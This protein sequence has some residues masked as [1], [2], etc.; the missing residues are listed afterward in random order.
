MTLS[1]FSRSTSSLQRGYSDRVNNV[2][3]HAITT[4]SIKREKRDHVSLLTLR[5]RSSVR[6]SMVSISIILFYG[7]HSNWFNIPA[8]L[9]W[10][11]S[12]NI[13]NIL[14]HVLITILLANEPIGMDLNHELSWI[15][16]F[17]LCYRMLYKCV[18]ICLS[19]RVYVCYISVPKSRGYILCHQ[20][21]V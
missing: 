6:E 11:Y 10:D 21:A 4:R 8:N 17:I 13:C 20:H 3:S 5:F 15:F 9:W 14:R 18:M 12:L 1:V 16:L 19:H 2:L 7:M